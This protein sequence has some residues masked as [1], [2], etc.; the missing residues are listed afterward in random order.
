MEI[1]FSTSGAE[2]NLEMKDLLNM[3]KSASETGKAVKGS[4]MEIVLEGLFVGE[5]VDFERMLEGEIN[6]LW[7]GMF[8]VLLLF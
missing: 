7:S 4:N 6:R 2:G 3:A 1:T 5:A 8:L